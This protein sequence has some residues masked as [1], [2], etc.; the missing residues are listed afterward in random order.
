[1]DHAE[2]ALAVGVPV[3]SA[4]EVLRAE[5]RLHLLLVEVDLA[6]RLHV[7]ARHVAGQHGRLEGA[8]PNFGVL[9]ADAVDQLAHHGARDAEARVDVLERRLDSTGVGVVP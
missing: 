7:R 2:R 9:G 4:R 8:D 1:M 5:R 3:R 6:M